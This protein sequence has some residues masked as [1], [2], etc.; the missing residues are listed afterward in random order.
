MGRLLPYFLNMKKFITTALL[1]LLLIVNNNVANAINVTNDVDHIY[2]NFTR[3]EVCSNRARK[4]WPVA[5]GDKSHPT[6]FIEGPTSVITHYKNGF[7][8]V[9]PFT[10]VVYKAGEHN[11]GKI[12]IQ[13]T[14]L[15]G[16]DIG[17]KLNRPYV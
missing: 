8:W 17:L 4:C 6:P 10:N 15:K 14:N 12:W 1:F 7:T 5:F 3:K 9:N 13:Y 11:L 2:L 16:I